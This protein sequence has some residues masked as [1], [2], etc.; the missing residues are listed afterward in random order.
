MSVSVIQSVRGFFFSSLSPHLF[1]AV[2]VVVVHFIY[3]T[4]FTAQVSSGCT[5]CSLTG[6]S[7]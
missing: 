4:S 6:L 5:Y 3:P 1:V 7:L 2:F